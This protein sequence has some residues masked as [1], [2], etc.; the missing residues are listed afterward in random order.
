MNLMTIL[1]AASAGIVAVAAQA[2]TAAPAPPPAAAAQQPS[3]ARPAY[4]EKEIVCQKEEVTGSRLATRRVCMTRG[5]W[6][7]A[8]MADKAE[9]EAIQRRGDASSK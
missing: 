9:L 4:D 6:M 7:R 5:E 8:K 3:T 2:Q 1:A